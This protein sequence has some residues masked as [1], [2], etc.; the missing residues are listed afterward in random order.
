MA[1]LRTPHEYERSGM[2]CCCNTP[3]LLIEIIRLDYPSHPVFWRGQTPKLTFPWWPM[4]TRGMRITAV[5]I[6]VRQSNHKLTQ[7]IA[8]TLAT[9]QRFS[10]FKRCTY[11]YFSLPASTD[12]GL[13]SNLITI[14]V[15]LLIMANGSIVYRR[16]LSYFLQSYYNAVT[17]QWHV[18]NNVM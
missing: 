2:R 11:M 17:T 1:Y 10:S 6:K 18:M 12:I 13:R 14:I 5:D 9:D 8:S 4:Y 16:T 3:W 7:A 15:L